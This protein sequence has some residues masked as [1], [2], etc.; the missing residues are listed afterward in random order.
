MKSLTI[1]M[2]VLLCSLAAPVFAAGGTTTC[3]G[4]LQGVTIPNNLY[5]PAGATCTLN[6]VE[7]IGNVTV[8]GSLVSFDG[9]FDSNVTVTGTISL[10]NG[11]DYRKIQ[12]NLTISNSSGQSGIYCPNTSNVINGNITVTGLN[13]GGSFYIC[14]ATVG[15][16]VS[17]TDNAGTIDISFMTIGKNLS[18][19]GNDPAPTS[20]ALVNQN[21]AQIT[22]QQKTGQC[23]AF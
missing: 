2:A 21:N 8:D 18:C 6:W 9:K 19:S 13:N 22:A 7:V 11:Y 5:V 23:S 17:L 16:G 12:G 14:S 1:C 15:G 10:I 4:P 3:T 20:W